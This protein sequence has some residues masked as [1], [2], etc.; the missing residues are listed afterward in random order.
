MFSDFWQQTHIHTH[1]SETN[2]MMINQ[3][4]FKAKENKLKLSFSVFFF[5]YK[6]FN[7]KK[8][9]NLQSVIVF[10]FNSDDDDNNRQIQQVVLSIQSW[11]NWFRLAG[12]WLDLMLNFFFSMKDVIS[13]LLYVDDDD[14][15]NLIWEFE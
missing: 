1:T 7:Q 4:L 3:N 14:E 15:F 13:F 5:L 11:K 12:I 9:K 8:K 6:S 2:H 10:S